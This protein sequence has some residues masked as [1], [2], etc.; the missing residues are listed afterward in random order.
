MVDLPMQSGDF[1]IAKLVYQR[2]SNFSGLYPHNNRSKHH[3]R[4]KPHVR[5][6]ERLPER[7]YLQ[8]PKF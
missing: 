7:W 2:L 8:G 6:V 4:A 5:C 3:P 1:P